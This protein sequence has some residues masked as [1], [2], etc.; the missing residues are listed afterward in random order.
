[1][2]Q[3][4]SAQEEQQRKEKQEQLDLQAKWEDEKSQ[5]QQRK[6]QFLVEQIE[7]Q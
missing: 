6:D 3:E 2:A 4:Q 1:L 7:T 5:L